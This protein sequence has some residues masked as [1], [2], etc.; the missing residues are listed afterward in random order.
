MEFCHIHK[1]LKQAFHKDTEIKN[2]N[3]TIE[4]KNLKY[5]ELKRQIDSYQLEAIAQKLEIARLKNEIRNL[6]ISNSELEEE[7]DS[8][9]EEKNIL[10]SD[11]DDYQQIKNFERIKKLINRYVDTTDFNQ[12]EHFMMQRKNKDI[13]KDILGISELQSDRI[14]NDFYAVYTKMRLRRNRLSHWWY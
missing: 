14:E 10:Q 6:E 2:L 4:K 12:I 8:L 3:K 5:Q 9:Q 7:N 1:K 11:F 13:L